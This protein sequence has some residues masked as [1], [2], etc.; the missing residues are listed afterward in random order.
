MSERHSLLLFGKTQPCSVTDY[1]AELP[2]EELFL[3]LMFISIR[4]L[5][6]ALGLGFSA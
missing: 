1:K 2:L 4:F 6:L 3:F 5:D